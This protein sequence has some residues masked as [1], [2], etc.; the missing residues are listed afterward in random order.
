MAFIPCLKSQTPNDMSKISIF[1]ISQK[2]ENQYILRSEDR[3]DKKMLS[4]FHLC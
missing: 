3:V 1:L 4:F 2:F